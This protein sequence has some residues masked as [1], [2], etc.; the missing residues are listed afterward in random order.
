[1]ETNPKELIYK[2]IVLKLSGQ[3]FQGKDKNETHNHANTRKIIEEIIPVA[4]RGVKII[5]V[6]G[7]GNIF[8]GRDS[9]IPGFPE[10]DADKMGMLGT[11]S[12]GIYLRGAMAKLDI[13]AGLFAATAM[14]YFMPYY[15]RET[16]SKSLDENG[17]III[18][19]GMGR[20]CCTTDHASVAYAL[21]MKAEAILKGTKVEGLYN[22]DPKEY[23]RVKL[24]PEISYKEA[25]QLEIEKIFDNSGFGIAKDKK[26]QIPLHIF[27][28]FEKGNLLRLMEGEK[29]GSKIVP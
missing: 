7:A 14:D 27:N 21:D 6:I 19:C 20:T 13:K 26:L 23:K 17:I 28:I 22:R 15:T 9:Q 29:I 2:R 16:A 11:A 1:M 18:T 25:L 12:N 24:I 5:I 8:R 3:I 10:D 4:E